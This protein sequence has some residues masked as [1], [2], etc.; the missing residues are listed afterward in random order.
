MKPTSLE[1]RGVAASMVD[2]GDG[3]ADDVGDDVIDGGAVV[4]TEF[5]VLVGNDGGVAVDGDSCCCVSGGGGCGVGGDVA[6]A[7]R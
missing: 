3:E 5:E 4:M 7:A 2:G 6:S 1:A